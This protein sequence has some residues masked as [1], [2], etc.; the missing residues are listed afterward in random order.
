MGSEARQEKEGRLKR[1][2][3][4]KHGLNK[5]PVHNSWRAMRERCRRKHHRQY[6]DYGG[7]GIKVCARW[8][9]FENFLADMG[10]PPKGYWIERV[11]K[12]GNYCPSNCKWASPKEQNR[13]RRDNRFIVIGGRKVFF[14]EIPSKYGISVSAFR[15]RYIRRKW[16]LRKALG[17]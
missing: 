6:K 5:T 10:H 3:N 1:S 14:F 7:R 12:N 16:P 13:N 8:K 15:N 4:F 2:N 17:L 11:N 9:K